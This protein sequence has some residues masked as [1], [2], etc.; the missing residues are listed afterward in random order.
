MSITP[1]S[2]P[3]KPPFADLL[4]AR[5]RLASSATSGASRLGEADALFNRFAATDDGADGYM[6]EMPVTAAAGGE[7]TKSPAAK[8]NPLAPLVHVRLPT[9][10]LL[11]MSGPSIPLLMPST[12]TL[13]AVS[14]PKGPPGPGDP[15]L[16]EGLP[17]PDPA[18][19][20]ADFP[21]GRTVRIHQSPEPR[22]PNADLKH[23]PPN[24]GGSGVPDGGGASGLFNALSAAPHAVAQ[25][26]AHVPAPVVQ[27]PPPYSVSAKIAIGVGTIIGVGA[28]VIGIWSAAD[29]KGANKAF[30]SESNSA[31][32]PDTPDSLAP[33]E[34]ESGT[35]WVSADTPSFPVVALNGP[36]TFGAEHGVSVA[37]ADIDL[38]AIRQ[39]LQ[40]FVA[41]TEDGGH[42]IALIG[43][44]GPAMP[45]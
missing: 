15:I 40:H 36:G 39:I 27:T 38:P 3:I 8:P 5:G 24:S 19:T 28:L 10:P 2:N 22:S 42:D 4:A 7:D 32:D 29:P 31:V 21:E 14:P 6:P 41:G 18:I 37:N 34:R 25:V 33:P 9:E 16:P 30:T 26:A 35:A 12:L 17:S 1:F 43:W 20:D 23:N 45:G 11:P 44:S 13:E